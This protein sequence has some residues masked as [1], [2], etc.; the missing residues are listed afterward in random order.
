MTGI[1]VHSLVDFGLH[2]M[3]NAMIFASLVVIATCNVS[4][5]RNPESED[6]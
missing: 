1:G 3:A 4:I 5:S 2:R 6:V